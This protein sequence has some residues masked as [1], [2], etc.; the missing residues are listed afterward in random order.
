MS[1]IAAEVAHLPAESCTLDGEVVVL[2]PDG[3]TSFADLQAAFQNDAKDPPLTYFVFDLLYLNGHNTRDLSLRD[4]KTLLARLL[5]R[6]DPHSLPLSD[7]LESNGPAVFHKACEMRAE[8]I[9]SKLASSKYTSGRS[10]SWLKCKCLHEQE[11][12]IGGFTLPSAG[13]TGMKGV[14]ALLL[15]Y[16]DGK[17]LIYAG[18]DVYKRQ[19]QYSYSTQ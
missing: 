16:Y 11:L 4:R 7:H 15:G 18:R 5:A 6:A 14:G 10:S 2:A 3:T 12:V 13:H 8:G 9:V 1:G 17:K 19:R